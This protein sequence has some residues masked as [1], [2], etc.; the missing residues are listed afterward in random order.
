MDFISYMISNMEYHNIFSYLIRFLLWGLTDIISTICDAVQDLF[1]NVFKLINFFYS[2][3]VLT[4]IQENFIPL[5]GVL[6]A[7]SL[8]M[9]GY[10]LITKSDDSERKGI[11]GAFSQNFILFLVIMFFIP[12]LLTAKNPWS[13]SEYN[14]ENVAMANEVISRDDVVMKVDPKNGVPLHANQ[15]GAEENRKKLNQAEK[16]ANGLINISRDSLLSSFEY[17][18]N[19][20]VSQS[21]ISK[22]ITDWLWVYNQIDNGKYDGEYLNDP[23]AGEKLENIEQKHFTFEDTSQLDINSRIVPTDSDAEDNEGISFNMLSWDKVVDTDSIQDVEENKSAA[24]NL[25]LFGDGDDDNDEVTQ[26][27]R[28]TYDNKVTYYNDSSDVGYSFSDSSNN[29]TEYIFGY[30]HTPFKDSDTNEIHFMDAN[31][32][33]GTFGI[34]WLGSYPYRYTIDWLPMLVELIATTLV[35]FFITFKAATLIWELAVN[36][37]LLY[38]FAAGDLTGGRKVREILKSMLSIFATILFVYIDLQVFLMACDFLD[39]TEIKGFSNALIKVFFAYACIDGPQ[40]LERVF[41]I[42]AGLKRPAAVLAGAAAIGVKAAKTTAHATG[43]M[44]K[45]AVGLGGYFAGRHAAHQDMNGLFDN[46]SND[47]SGRHSNSNDPSSTNGSNESN[48]LH[49]GDQNTSPN[50]TFEDEAVN[51][52]P[53]QENDNLDDAFSPSKE[54]LS[55]IAEM[56]GL[57]GEIIDLSDNTASAFKNWATN[58]V[59]NT[60]SDNSSEIGESKDEQDVYKNSIKEQCQN[61]LGMSDED[62]EKVANAM[63]NEMYGTDAD[64]DNSDEISAVKDM[65]GKYLDYDTATADPSEGGLGMTAAEAMAMKDNSADLGTEYMSRMSDKATEAANKASFNSIGSRNATAS[66]RQV[67]TNTRADALG[68]TG[69]TTNVSNTNVSGNTEVNKPDNSYIASSSYVKHG[70][71]KS[72]IFMPNTSKIYRQGGAVGYTSAMRKHQKEQLKQQK[73]EQKKKNK[74][75]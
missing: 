8:I 69:N 46:D 58:G 50:T 3:T 57:T 36:H 44:K 34:D 25:T 56:A 17:S 54:E 45:G 6:L 75:K 27:I 22:H 13:G 10:N 62:A 26:K 40:I 21:V 29:F 66:A 33:D 71:G 7:V 38:I 73:K 65:V 2:S 51:T 5:I 52:N 19:K 47:E 64:S 70:A 12:L 37:I 18:K 32:D 1:E 28:G 59:D 55:K 35:Y 48:S 63:T 60:M 11:I 23:S 42:D 14:L 61:D 31:C 16:D 74:E 30:R 68:N 43:S 67:E 4:Y 39:T 15:E 9:L 20:S 41:G 49:N 24:S 72:S 53:N